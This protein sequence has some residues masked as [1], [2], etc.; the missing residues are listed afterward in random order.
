MRQRKLL[1][2]VQEYL[3]AEERNQMQ[4]ILRM[5]DMKEIMEREGLK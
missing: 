3:P 5:M 1:Q 4:T 2:A